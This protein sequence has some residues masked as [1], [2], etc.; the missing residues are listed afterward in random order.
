MGQLVYVSITGLKVRHIWQ[1]PVFWRH[2]IASMSQA[3]AAKGC[4]GAEAQ[5][6]NGIHHTRSIWRDRDAMLTYLRTGAHLNAMKVFRKIAT[7]RTY[8][9]ETTDIPDWESVHQLWIERG[10]EA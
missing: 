9:F 1:Q 10:Q 4:L 2:A 7:G 5:T 3:Q 6:I 8:G